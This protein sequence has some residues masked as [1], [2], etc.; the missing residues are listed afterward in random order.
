[1]DVPDSVVASYPARMP[2]PL[3]FALGGS[4]GLEPQGQ[5]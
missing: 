3:R 5:S 4:V 1:M 2:E